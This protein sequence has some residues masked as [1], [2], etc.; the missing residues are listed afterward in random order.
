MMVILMQKI[1]LLAM[2][3]IELDVRVV[4]RMLKD[5]MMQPMSFIVVVRTV[6]EEN[7]ILVED[8]ISIIKHELTSDLKFDN[9]SNVNSGNNYNY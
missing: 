9:F 1:L 7:L 4:Y 3:M 2:I 5:E 6:S 8:D